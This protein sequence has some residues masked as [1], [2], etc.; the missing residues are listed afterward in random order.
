MSDHNS[1]RMDG[2]GIVA[3]VVTTQTHTHKQMVFGV[4]EPEPQV[5]PGFHVNLPFTQLPRRIRR[6]LLFDISYCSLLSSPPKV[7]TRKRNI[8]EW[9]RSMCMR[10]CVIVFGLICDEHARWVH[11]PRT[12]WLHKHQKHHKIPMYLCIF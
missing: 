10:S 3:I 4:G 5:I 7:Y 2:R 9:G 11:H 6:A 1:L 8:C 12:R